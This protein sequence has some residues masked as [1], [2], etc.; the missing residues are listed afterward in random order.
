MNWVI[1]FCVFIQY[2]FFTIS[3]IE[4]LCSAMNFVLKMVQFPFKLEN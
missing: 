2:V 1:A 4:Y 3:L